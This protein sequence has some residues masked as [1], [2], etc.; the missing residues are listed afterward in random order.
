M[1]MNTDALINEEVPR[2]EKVMK[3]FV[4][5]RYTE[6]GLLLGGVLLFIF[7]RSN[8]ERQLWMGIG[9]G[10]AL[11]AAIML[12]ADGLAERRGHTYLEGMKSYLHQLNNPS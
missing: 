6:I 5:Y 9:A 1:D 3:N 2:M 11:Q 8:P 10:L 4:V 7:F 12:L